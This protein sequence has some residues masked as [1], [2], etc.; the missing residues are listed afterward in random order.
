MELGRIIGIARYPVKSLVGEHLTTATVDHRGIEGD[1]LWAVRDPDGKLGSGK[2]TR[3]FRRMP[4]LL[5][6]RS[7]YDADRTPVVDF[8]DGRSLRA[9]APEV[10]GALS[11]HVGRPVT[12]A[13]ES[14]VSHF[15]EGP[16]HLVTRASLARAS[17]LHGAEV[18]PRRLRAN[19]V[20]DTGQ[21]PRFDEGEWIGRTLRV[22]AGVLVRVRASMPRCVMVGLPQV[23]L[24]EDGRLLGTIADGNDTA[25]GLVLDVLLPGVIGQGDAVVAE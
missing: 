3:R 11:D 4:G 24:P 1:R 2:S 14:S 16:L 7:R 18:D 21:D 20:V 12:L 9:D 5:S 8:P 10:H 19:L 22:G 25:L 15:D 13:R 6:L 17:Q 23:G